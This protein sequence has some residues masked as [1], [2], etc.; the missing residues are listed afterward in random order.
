MTGL[1]LHIPFCARKCPYCDFYSVRFDRQLVADYTAALVRNIRHLADAEI[2]IDSIYFGGGTP[3]LLC[4]AQ[5][6][7]VLSA[8]S[9]SFSLHDPEITLEANPC[10]VDAQKLREYRSAGV[11]RL[12]FGVQSANDDELSRLGRLHNFERAEK[13]VSDAVSAGFENISCD[14]ML[15]TAGQTIESLAHSAKA[16]AKL[17]IQHISAY[18]LKIEKGT[19]YDCDEMRSASADDELMSEMYLQTVES[20]AAA[21]FLQYEISNFAK[22]GFESRHNLKYWTGE[23]YIGLG[24][25]AHSFFGGKR[26]ACPSDVNAFVSSDVQRNIITDDSPDAL[27]EYIMLGLRLTK[28]V[29]FERLGELGADAAALQKTVTQLAQHGLVQCGGDSFALTPK[30]FLLSNSIISELLAVV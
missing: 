13:A 5:V 17:P 4:S 14:I 20:L 9:A 18:M 6:E 26:Y 29:S 8:A 2:H 10:T 28:G 22:Q 23:S 11:D 27:E 15:G 25:S 19:P 30:G 16:L 7:S 12:S 1:Y 3:S 21:G 24:A